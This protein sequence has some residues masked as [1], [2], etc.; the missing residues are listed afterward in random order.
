MQTPHSL[1][2]CTRK[3][4]LLKPKLA[5]DLDQGRHQHAKGKDPDKDDHETNVGLGVDLA[6]VGVAGDQDVPEKDFFKMLF[7][8]SDDGHK[9]DQI[10]NS[11][12]DLNFIFFLAT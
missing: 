6:V 3:G 12:N 8:F 1:Q 11:K 4:L 2:D 9:T 5:P 7:F 10:R